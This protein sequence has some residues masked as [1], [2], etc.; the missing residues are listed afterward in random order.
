MIEQKV[1]DRV[2]RR[3]F[4]SRLKQVIGQETAALLA[5]K[6]PEVDSVEFCSFV[7]NLIVG[8]LHEH[9]CASSGLEASRDDEPPAKGDRSSLDFETILRGLLIGLEYDLLVGN[10]QMVR[11]LGEAIAQRDTLNSK[12]NLRVTLY[13]TRLAE[14]MGLEQEQVQSLMKGSFLHDIGKIGIHDEILLKGADLTKDERTIMNGHPEIGT[15]MISGVKWLGDALDVVRHHHERYD[16]AGYPD[17]LHGETVPLNARI[18]AVVDVF[19]AL[20]SERPYKQAYQYEDT[21]AIINRKGGGH[22]DPEIVDEFTAI[23]RS[24]YDELAWEPYHVL[25]RQVT[26]SLATHFGIDPAALT[27]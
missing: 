1:K 21:M 20:A 17:G 10:L 18:F 14:A 2:A 8:E 5:E 3:L 13:S 26:N 15:M 24:L 25:D 22:F 27:I 7:A 6:P 19:D 16:G 11:A 9:L 4:S 23:S 12:H